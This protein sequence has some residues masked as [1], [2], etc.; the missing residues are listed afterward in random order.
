M[1]DINEI[2]KELYRTKKMAKFSHY[3]G[4]NLYY[5]IELGEGIFQFVIPT[6]QIDFEMFYAGEDEIETM[7]LSEDLGSTVF[8]NEIKG[9]ELIRWMQKSIDSEDFVK[10]TTPRN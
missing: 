9:S 7:K 3:V 8:W 6:I 10:I 5:T 4:G 1:F 2:K